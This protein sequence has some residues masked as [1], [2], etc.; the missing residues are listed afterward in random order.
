MSSLNT[1]TV[2]ASM[3]TIT[4]MTSTMPCTAGSP[5]I[6]TVSNWKYLVRCQMSGLFRADLLH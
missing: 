6:Q 2:T 3:T 5:L 4:Q 1:E